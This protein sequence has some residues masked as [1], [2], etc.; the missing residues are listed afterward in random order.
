[1]RDIS[2]IVIAH[3]GASGYRPEHTL[4]SYTLAITQGADFIEPDLVATKDHHLICR[5]ENALA[6]LNPDG[7]LN[8]Q[9][10]ST[11]VYRRADFANRLATK[12]IDSREVRGWFSED[13]TLAEIK[14]LR[15]VE[16]IPALRPA[17]TPYNGQFEIPTFDEVIDLV[18]AHAAKTG[19]AVGI[20]PETKH[21]TYFQ[22]E[23]RGIDGRLIGVNL[24]ARIIQTLLARK[25][26][27][28]ERIFIQS[29][30][31][32][33]LRELRQTL[34]PQAGLDL[35][36]IQLIEA[37]GVPYDQRLSSTLDYRAMTTPTGLQQISQYANGVGV[38]KHYVIPRT[39]TNTLGAPSR[40]IPD[41][42][43]AGLLVHAWTFRAENYFLPTSLRLGTNVVDRGNLA[44]EIRPFLD[45]GLDGVFCDHPDI[46]VAS[47]R[48]FARG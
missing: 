19:R 21:P 6:V 23:G 48:L 8:T 38:F 30:E 44:D 27:S 43:A 45:A 17:N 37:D 42:H 10:T 11:D 9:D 15:A 12:I 33:N 4:A 20:Y 5:H 34:L 31:M 14:T 26:T 41:A 32:S 29:F 16:R 3:R 24:G 7:S 40:L 1:M 36:L 46:A 13:F 39:P 2:P 47:T 35:P 28:P 18:N 25:F 22:S